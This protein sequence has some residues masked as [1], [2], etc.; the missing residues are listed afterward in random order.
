MNRTQNKSKIKIHPAA[1]EMLVNSSWEYAKKQLWQKYEFTEFEAELAKDFIREFYNS[2]PAD[3]FTKRGLRRLSAFCKRVDLA[4][5]YVNRFNHR[6]IP[7]PAIWLNPKNPKGFAG[8]KAW[9]ER[10]NQ[11]DNEDHSHE[12]VLVFYIPKTQLA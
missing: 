1:T 4:A 10:S 8:T 11:K 2:I 5:K 12:M 3:Q 7:H 6:Y 9:L